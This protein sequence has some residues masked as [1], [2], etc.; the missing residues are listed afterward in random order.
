MKKTQNLNHRKALFTYQF[1]FYASVFLS[2]FLLFQIQPLIGKYILPWFGGGSSV[3]TTSILFF[4]LFLLFGYAYA[5]FL[6][7]LRLKQQ[8]I[9]HCILLII[10]SLL[11]ITLFFYWDSPVTPPIEIR[12]KD[13]FPPTIQ[14]LIVL[15]LSVGLPYFLLS[16]TSSLLQRWFSRTNEKLSPYPLYALSNAG[17]LLGLVTYP[18]IVEVLLPLHTQGVIWALSFLVFSIL[19]AIASIVTIRYAKKT[20]HQDTANIV[21]SQKAQAGTARRYLWIILPMISSMIL[22]STTSQIT[23]SVA[24]A[25]FLWIL[26]LGLYLLSFILCFSNKNL[27]WRNIYAYLLLILASV[28]IYISLDLQ[29][30]LTNLTIYSAF[31]FVSFMLLHGELYNARPD[32]KHLNLFYF[33]EAL[34]SA[35]GGVFVAIIAPQIFTDF[36]EFYI[37]AFLT[38][39]VAIVVLFAYKNS[40]PHIL[41]EKLQ[42]VKKKNYHTRIG[43]AVAVLVV[44]AGFTWIIANQDEVIAKTRNFYGIVSVAQ[45][46]DDNDEEYLTMYNGRINHGGQYTSET[47][48]QRPVSYYGNDSGISLAIRRHPNRLAPKSQQ[49]P[50]RIGVTG[51]GVGT[52]AA[53]GKRGD[54][55]AFYEINPEAVNAAYEYFTYLE[56]SV[57][58]VSIVPGDARISMENRIKQNDR[59]IYDI[60]ILDAFVDDS[61]PIH[62]ITKEA[63]DLYLKLLEPKN[64]IIAVNISNKYLSLDP[65]IAKVAEHFGLEYALI[66][67]YDDDYNIAAASWVI[68]TRNKDFIQNRRIAE[69]ATPQETDLN[70]I[71]LW[72]DQ[73]SNLFQALDI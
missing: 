16:T 63:F 27:Y 23:Q 47:L 61:I 67:S 34:G 9:M 3:W 11:L 1:P 35:L 30:F 58:D 17:S 26:P 29:E 21:E 38:V 41:L 66:E 51:L 14:V 50:L 43:V 56:D 40:L 2:A 39:S 5:Y 37:A 44:I 64:G 36:W 54:T 52:L 33:L 42:W 69:V 6:T 59:A 46:Y 45:E 71:H 7:R 62:L 28:T 57:A 70:K 22:L 20:T 72:T 24:P 32:A 65:I 10:V 18:F 53:F 49:K 15:F 12:P 55:I 73:Y 60:I 25:P 19:L 31:I 48:K 13:T 8:I 4:E 68:L